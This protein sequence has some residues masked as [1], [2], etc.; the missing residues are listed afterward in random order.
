MNSKPPHS[1]SLSGL[2]RAL[3]PT[4]F[5]EIAVCTYTLLIGSGLT[6]AFLSKHAKPSGLN[7]VTLPVCEGGGYC[8]DDRTEQNSVITGRALQPSNN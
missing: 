3:F 7:L 8:V 1:Q 5:L 4:R 6:F 2:S